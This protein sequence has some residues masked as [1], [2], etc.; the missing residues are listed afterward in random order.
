MY[1]K[2]GHVPTDSSPVHIHTHRVLRP[3][4]SRA[5]RLQHKRRLRPVPQAKPAPSRRRAHQAAPR[6]R[7]RRPGAGGPTP[8]VP[9]PLQRHPAPRLGEQRSPTAAMSPRTK[10][11]VSQQEAHVY[12]KRGHVPTDSSREHTRTQPAHPPRRPAR[13]SQHKHKLPHVPQAKPA[14]SHKRARRVAPR[15]RP[16]RP[17][18]HGA[19]RRIR[20]LR[21]NQMR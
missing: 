14:P 11:R 21:Y 18:A 9:A 5:P 7:A 1:R 6:E 15:V 8:Q 2:R 17:G 10:R 16:R 4:P 20:V 3:L 19:I 12:R 13:R